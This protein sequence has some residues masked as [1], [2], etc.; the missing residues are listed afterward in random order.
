MGELLDELFDPLGRLELPELLSTL[1]EVLL[2]GRL[3]DK[4]SEREGR[5][6]RRPPL[7]ALTTLL[8]F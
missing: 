8:T 1:V 4:K 3:G 7:L 6:L 2:L 5:S